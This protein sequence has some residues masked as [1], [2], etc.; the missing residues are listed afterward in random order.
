MCGKPNP[1]E[2]EVCKYCQARLKPLIVPTPKKGEDEVDWLRDLAGKD[3][4]PPTADPDTGSEQNSEEEPDW[5]TRIRLKTKDEQDA[6]SPIGRPPKIEPPSL[7]SPS[8]MADSLE[9]AQPAQPG[10]EDW[11]QSLRGAEMA[12]ES[13]SEPQN[14]PAPAPSSSSNSEDMNNDDWLRSL[15]SRLESSQ[16]YQPYS[17]SSDSVHL[18]NI[19]DGQDGEHHP[20]QNSGSG[21]PPAPLLPDEPLLGKAEQPETDTPDWSKSIGAAETPAASQEPAAS[22]SPE[23][24]TDLSEWLKSLSSADGSAEAGTPPPAAPQG[25]AAPADVPDWLKAFAVEEPQLAAPTQPP[26]PSAPQSEAAP[27]DVPDWL[28]AFAVEEPQLAVPTL[29]AAPSAAQSEAA[30]ADV[31]DWLNAFA[32]AKEPQAVAP[33]QPAE[34]PPAP[35]ALQG[36]ATPAEGIPDWLKAFTPPSLPAI[37]IPAADAEE[38]AHDQGGSADGIPEWLQDFTTKPAAAK[39]TPAPEKAPLAAPGGT[40][41]FIDS[42]PEA[43]APVPEAEAA[44]GEEIPDWLK[45]YSQQENQP[46]EPEPEPAESTEPV[47]ISPFNDTNL[48]EWMLSD[49]AALTEQPVPGEE[50]AG[51]PGAGQPELT[52]PALTFAGDDVSQWL[53]SS[54]E[55]QGAFD[56]AVTN[57]SQDNLELAPLPAWLQ[58]M[59]PVESAALSGEESVDE[60]RVEKSGPLAGLRSVLR[61]EDLVAQYQKLPSYSVKLRVSDPQT[62]KAGLMEQVIGDESKPQEV[63]SESI[64]ATQALVRIATGLALIALILIVIFFGPRPLAPAALSL[65]D[66]QVSSINRLVNDLAPGSPVLVAVDYQGGLSGELRIAAQPVIQHL[67]SRG[68]RL[69]FIS[70]QPEGPALAE[71]LFSTARLAGQSG[72]PVELK[73]NLGYLI[74]GSSALKALAASPL[75]F[76]IPQ[77]WSAGGWN[78]IALANLKQIT[79]FSQVVLLTDTPESARDWVEQVQPELAKKNKPLI[80]IS[81]AQAAPLLRPYQESGQ[82]TALLSGL[83]GGAAYEQIRQVSGYG[84]SY[85]NAYLAGIL[86]MVLFILMGGIVSLISNLSHSKT[87]RK[88]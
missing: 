85:W 21:I 6:V 80:V 55:E 15:G 54:V 4:Q 67:M 63:S 49:Q 34:L 44:K 52:G 57:A 41:A 17:S 69:I 1:A 48:P 65:V 87:K 28:K 50:P 61:S 32:L 83:L 16:P 71:S 26:A 23:P 72:Y 75:Q 30:P 70:T 29:P 59:R 77:T 58:A 84:T 88:V 81:S 51:A 20:S 56:E 39:E 18:Q 2:A 43:S 76:S 25:E 82:I 14:V 3:S 9:P 19:L 13:A 11:L 47:Y 79:D 86:A 78:Q 12:G 33:N 74:G 5:L 37:E 73:A 62:L 38:P 60:Q 40:T 22:V 31:P 8:K 66:P 68:A 7:E 64:F 35:A 24:S 45:T 42:E 27:A 10:G 46:A 53:D 36:E